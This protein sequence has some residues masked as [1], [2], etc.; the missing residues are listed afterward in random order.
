M[1]VN[2]KAILQEE[3]GEAILF[4]PETLL[5][6]WLN[7]SGIRIWKL[8]QTGSS[9]EGIVQQ[10]KKDYEIENEEALKSDV[11][12]FTETLLKQGF[13]LKD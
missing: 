4:D 12:A 7:E 1:R 8:L 3:K 11:L 13:I 10:M 9:P 2:P 6:F 5:T